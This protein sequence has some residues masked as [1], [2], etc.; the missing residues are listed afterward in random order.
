MGYA[1]CNQGFYDH[2]P[3]HIMDDSGNPFSCRWTTYL[4]PQRE[5][6]SELEEKVTPIDGLYILEIPVK[7]IVDLHPVIFIW[8][9]IYF[10]GDRTIS[11]PG[12]LIPGCHVPD[13]VR[14]IES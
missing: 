6:K 1:G 5:E 12:L 2:E 4:L 11:I 10:I 8:V 7:L 9:I 14:F 13:I 3:S